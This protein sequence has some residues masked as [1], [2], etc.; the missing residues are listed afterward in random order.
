MVQGAASSPASADEYTGQDCPQTYQV[1]SNVVAVNITAIGAAG[2]AGSSDA[3]SG[4]GG[5]GAVV[6]AQVPVTPGEYLDAQPAQSV[7]NGGPSGSGGADNLGGVGGSSSY[8]STEDADCGGPIPASQ[9]LVEA[10]G[11][12]GGGAGEHG[13]L[14]GEYDGGNGGNAGSVG[15][16]GGAASGGGNSGQGGGGATQSGGGAGGAAGS[17][18][19][20]EDSDGPG[21]SGSLGLG[22][23][24]GE[25]DFDCITNPITG[26]I[27]CN[28]LGGSAGGGGGGGYSG[29]GGGGGGSNHGS[30]GG[31]GGSNYVTPSATNITE[32]LSTQQPSVTITPA[33]YATS[34]TVTSSINP[35]QTGQSVQYTATVTG[36]PDGQPV[37]FSATQGSTQLSLGTANLSHGVAA[38]S[39]ALGQGTWT[40]T[41]N[42]QGNATLAPS[43]G[44]VTQVAVTHV[45]SPPTGLTA[46]AVPNNQVSLSWTAPAQNGGG[47]ITGYDVYQGTTTGGES[48]TPVNA[49][50]LTGTSDSLSGL[51]DGTTYFFTV[52][53]INSAGLSPASAEASV[54]VGAATGTTVTVVPPAPAN[55]YVADEYDRQVTELPLSGGA[56]TT[57]GSSL[58]G[59]TAVAADGAGDV[60]IG[61]GPTGRVVEVP[62]GGGAQVAVGTFTDVEGLALDGA[63]DLYV[64]DGAGNDVLEVP[65]GG[66]PTRTIVSGLHDPTAVAVDAA[67]DLFIADSQAN[68]VLEVPT[69]GRPQTTV[70]TGLNGPDG[71]AVDAAGDVFIADSTNN[72]VVKVPA[73]GGSQGTVGSGLHYPARLAVDAAGDL[74]VADSGND[75]VVE[76]TPG[77][78]QSTLAFPA[79][80]DPVAV[81]AGPTPSAVSPGSSVTLRATVMGSP[82]GTA[83]TGTVTFVAGSTT[84]GH[85]DL[86]G[87]PATASLTTSALPTGFDQVTASYA[88]D[89]DS[90]PST[91]AS[92]A[93]TVANVPSAP[94]ALTATAGSGQATLQ[95]TAPSSNGGVPVTGY[96]VYQGTSAGHESV[97]PVNAAPVTGTSYTATGL[98]NGTTYFFTVRAVNAVGLSPASN[99]A[100]E[101]GARPTGTTVSAEPAPAP[102]LFIADADNNRIAEVAAGGGTPTTFAGGQNFPSTVATDSS[103]DVFTVNGGA[104]DVLEIPAGGGSSHVVLSGLSN[105]GGVAVDGAGDVFVADNGNNRVLEVPAGGGGTRTVG[106]GLVDPD[107]VAVDTVGDVFVTEPSAGEVVEIPA[108]GGPQ[109]VINRGIYDPVGVAVDAAGNLYV[110]DFDLGEVLEYGAIGGAPRVIAS[111]L[112][113]PYG[114]AVDGSDDVYVA[115][116]D[117]V[118]EIAPDGT[119]TV[120]TDYSHGVTDARGVAVDVPTAHAIP[121][122]PVTLQATVTSSPY[123]SAPTGTVT[124]KNGGTT[125]GTATLSGTSPTTASIT[126]SSLPTGTASIT[127]TYGGDAADLASA[128]SAPIAVSIQPTAP[129]APTGLALTNGSGQVSLTWTAPA[130]NGGSTLLGYNVYQGTSSGGESA[131]PVNA[132][133]ITGT[134]D[135]VTGLS[136]TG[137]YYFVVKAVNGVGSSGPSNEV[138][139]SRSPTG[140]SVALSPAPTPK[141]VVADAA[142]GVDQYSAAGGPAQPLGSGLNQPQG[143][144]ADAAGDVFIGDTSNNRVVEEP[145]GGG[146][147]ITVATGVN[148]IA[149]AVD[150]SGDLYVSDFSGNRVV[151]YPV[152]GGGPVTVMSGVDHPEGVAVDAAGDVYVS[153]PQE[154]NV[155]ELPVGQI[156]P[157]VAYHEV[158]CGMDGLAVD[159]TGTLYVAC[160]G[161]TSL[162]EVR[163]GGIVAAAGYGVGF[164]D[165]VG[166][167]VDPAG[168]VFVTNHDTGQLQEYPG[169]NLLNFNYVV[170]ASGY[171]NLQGVAVVPTRS[172]AV[173]GSPASVTATVQTSPAGGQPTGPVTFSDGAT[174]LG[175]AQL[176]GTFPD[177]ATFTTSSL[178]QGVHSLTASYGG[179]PDDTPSGPSAPASVDVEPTVPSAPVGVTATAGQAQVNL[180]WFAPQSNG[181]TPVTGYD[182][183]QGTSPGGESATPVNAAPITGTND[184]VT[185]LTPG[186]TY[187]FTVRAA[188]SQ[189]L[190]AAS[191][192][193]NAQPYA[194][195]STSLGADPTSAQPGQAVTLTAT[196]QTSP[197]G[198]SPTGTVT[199][200]LGSTTLGTAWLNGGS[201][202]TA[203]LVTSSLP[204]GADA[205]TASF[206]GQG[207]DRASGPSSPVTVTVEPV[208]PSAPSGLTARSAGHGQI[209]LSWNAPSANG[210][211]PVTGYDVYQGTSP[212]QE[213]ATPINASPLSTTSDTVSGLNDGTPYYFTVTASNVAGASPGSNEASATPAAASGTTLSASPPATP[214]LFVADSGLGQVVEVPA[215]G[216][217]QTPVGTG[218]SDPSDTAV[219]AAGDVFIADTG[220]NRVVEVPAGGGSQTRVGTGLSGPAGVAVDAAGDVFIAD[221]RHNRVVE[222]PA[223][224]GSQTTVGSGLSDPSGVAVDAAGDVFIADT[225][226]NRV[227]EVPAGGGSQTTVGT[228]LSDPSGVAVDAAGDVFIADTGNARVVEVPAG[229]SSQTAV[230]T[231][232]SAPAGVAVDPA[233]DVFIADTGNARVVEVPAG[234]GS[235]TTVGS[236]FSFPTGLAADVPVDHAIPGATV[237]VQAQVET[238][239]SG[240]APS[241]SVT[242][243][244]GATVL[245]TRPLSGSA[246]DT[247][248]FSTASLSTGTHELTATYSGNGAADPSPASAPLTVS[249]EPAVPGSPTG[250]TA[251]GQN[252]QVS[253]SWTAPTYTGGAPVTGYDVYMGTTP[254]GESVTP[255]NATPI[256]GTTD[257]VNGLIDGTPYYFTVRALNVAGASPASN[258][259]AATPD[260]RT[261]TAVTV[262]PPPAAGLVVAEDSNSSVIELPPGGGSAHYVGASFSGPTGLATDTLGDVFVADNGNNR[263]IEDPAAGGQTTVGTGLTHPN[264]VAVDQS[265]DVFIADS[266]NNRVVE[267]PAGGGPQ[268][269]LLSGLSTPWGVATDAAGDVFV[270]DT[271]NNRVLEL[272]AVGGNPI[273]LASGLLHPQAIAADVQGDVF[274][275]DTGNNQVDEI[276]AGGGALTTLLGP[277]SVTAPTGVAV[278]AAGNLYVSSQVTAHIVELPAGG[279]STLSLGGSVLTEPGGVAAVPGTTTGLPG[280]A[281]TL[282]ATVITSPAGAPLSGNVAF[283]QGGTEL[284]TATV[285]GNSPQTAS[286]TTTALPLGSDQVTAIYNGDGQDLASTSGPTTVDVATAPG[287]PTNLTGLAADT[288]ANL[289]WTPPVQ[290]NAGPVTGYDVYQGTASGGEGATPINPSP[291]TGTTDQVTGLTDGHA[292]YFTVKAINAEGISVASNEVSVTPGAGSGIVVTAVPAPTPDIYVANAGN[293]VVDKITGTTGS[294]TGVASSG[295]QEVSTDAIGDF[296]TINPSTSRVTEYP[297]SGGPTISIGSGLNY[298]TQLAVDPK[299]DIFIADTDNQRVVEEPAG[300]G[301]QIV[302]ASVPYPSGI[303]TDSAGDVYVAAQGSAQAVYK[304]SPGGVRSTFCS[305]LNFPQNITTNAAGDV[306]V[307]ENSIIAECF[308][309]GGEGGI[310]SGWQDVTGVAVDAAGNVYGTDA[311]ANQVVKVTPGGQ[312]STVGG[313]WSTPTAVAVDV[314]TAYRATGTPVT[315]SATLLSSSGLL[316]AGGVNFNSGSTLLGTATALGAAPGSADTASITTSALPAGTDQVT[317]TFVGSSTLDGATSPPI[318]VKV[319]PAPTAPTGLTATAGYQSASLSWTAA[320]ANGGDPVTGY[321]IYQGTS[322][323][324]E[325]ATPINA[326]PVTGTSY[327]ATGLSNG[328]SYYFRVKAVNL[329]GLSPASN[330][331]TATPSVPTGISVTTSPAATPDVFINDRA[332]N[333]VVE[334]PAGGGAQRVLVTGLNNP[335]GL[336]VDPAGDV[337]VPDASNNRVLEIFPNGTTTTVGTGLKNPVGVALDSSG[338]VFIADNGN[339]RIVEV[340]AQGVQ[341]VVP[342]SGLSGPSD[343]AVDSANDL[344]IVDRSNDRVLEIPAG[345]GPQTTVVTGL[346]TTQGMGVDAAGDLYIANTGANAVDEV[347]AG[348]STLVPILTGPAV[349]GPNDV[350]VDAGGDVFV[351]DGN[352]NRILEL[353]AGG[354]P[355]TTV[356]TGLL[357]PFSVSVDEPPTSLASTTTT[358]SATVLAP[359][360]AGSPAGTVTF[361]TGST[362]LGTAP[363]SGSVPDRATLTTSALAVGTNSITATYNAQGVYGSSTSA[364]ETVQ[365]TASAPGAPTALT[366][367]AAAGSVSLSWTAPASNG[368]APLTGYNVY[369]G[370]SPGGEAATPVNPSPLSGTSDTISGLTN[371]QTYYFTVKAVNA[372]GSSAPSNEFTASP[373]VSSSL[374][375]TDT[376]AGVETGGSFAFTATVSSSGTTPTGTV[377]WALTGPGSPTCAPSTL[378]NGVGSCTVSPASAGT[379]TAAATYA[380]DASHRGS[381]GSDTEATVAPAPI[382]ATVSGQQTYASSPA[383]SETDDAPGGVSLVGTLTCTGLAGPT[384]VG[385]GLGVGTYTVDPNTC[386]GLSPSDASD[387]TVVYQG[388]PGGFAVTP[389]ATTVQLARTTSGTRALFD[390]TV[391]GPGATPTGTVSWTITGH[392]PGRC[393]S[394]TLAGGQATCLL[395]QGAASNDVVTATYSGDADHQG[396][397]FTT[398]PF[399]AAVNGGSTASVPY[400]TPATF[401]EAGLPAGASG[402]VAFRTSGGTLLCTVTLPATSCTTAPTLGGGSYPGVTA[403]YS[404]DPSHAANTATSTLSLTVRALAQRVAFTTPAPTGAVVGGTAPVAATGGASGNPVVLTVSGV[405]VPPP[406]SVS[407]GTL[408]FTHAGTC[409]VTATQAAS[410]DYDA[411]K[412]TLQFHIAGLATATSLTAP[413]SLT[414]GAEGAGR[415]SVVVTAAQGTPTGS[416]NVMAGSTVLC[417]VRLTSSDNG[418]CSPGRSRLASGTYQVS[419]RFQ[420]NMADYLTSQSAPASLLVQ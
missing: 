57:V 414:A 288:G 139:T 349:S 167:A 184:T 379:Y 144:A 359:A 49:S 317:A 207:A 286:L 98:V 47:A 187:Y 31:G 357:G 331:A 413:S 296:F 329:E 170:L 71:L 229:G 182:V 310:G 300:G 135:T 177:T 301:A 409:I 225:G 156:S 302:F 378:V 117:Q 316:P 28:Q 12:G 361:R 141:V 99:E 153:E 67:G 251:T 402:T 385:P 403:A 143:V 419:A 32:G 97:T 24:G 76:I 163:N 224:G 404:G 395:T 283:W 35:S 205:I 110:S 309:G 377:T 185:G 146:G 18:D 370:T 194:L 188:N 92:T 397:S 222:V 215:G 262:S 322:P 212:G 120:A 330:E 332:N 118:I 352:N 294:S 386:S 339:N 416:V 299:G 268:Q 327:S 198:G 291:I 175:T 196:V 172:S 295:S 90:G 96:D 237:T 86:S 346:G 89:S 94:R 281:V 37:T 363:L 417:T 236:G 261:G 356:G 250:L 382:T 313:G 159:G 267:V 169:G 199:F 155:L 206:G 119:Q 328:T 124:F 393:Q 107:Q 326:S 83:A 61:E 243:A 230:G 149:L 202:D 265:G 140:I 81:A 228:G 369:Q 77:G 33:V 93:V 190:G 213:G 272:P 105:P 223:G 27:S 256:T 50:P 334:V 127:A 373:L 399:T 64:A 279:G 45:P 30:G 254:G 289:S 342:T 43:S 308:P 122:A 29:G 183:Y 147:Q 173:L 360:L 195:T 383:F 36:V 266:G 9:L 244:D 353:P 179:D 131:T 26:I 371:G 400:G 78:S 208:A 157:V 44:S 388:A 239:P 162:L 335:R 253:L 311:E 368:G 319:A 258:E 240:G 376:A 108:G 62:A 7:Q 112:Y 364:P 203:T 171:P 318:T 375:V 280:A 276:P 73:G 366:G 103:G 351:A 150:A 95:W 56:A 398:T 58:Q 365:T 325:S 121:G 21:T 165:P 69:N 246:P 204:T 201:P 411:G 389:A 80:D 84:L 54:T 158:N 384:A 282:T 164:T 25:A 91:S 348:T 293:G 234:G 106:S 13:T 14:Y 343:L 320:G 133:L 418:S 20:S 390:A 151:E 211:A 274:V 65:A 275:A 241:G 347:P 216:G 333:R 247:A 114:L 55:V 101:A 374:G 168:D 298:P 181:G 186:T 259:A 306:Y 210:G 412:A 136:P 401:S 16:A 63:G 271:G 8:V 273:T 270:A 314:P 263:V 129:G 160:S 66:G 219:D 394:Q 19:S 85:A 341:S 304:Y 200:T 290:G 381:S 315:L 189:G 39:Y 209:T 166:V 4:S 257:T 392:F 22:G 242:F 396:S 174:T 126:T 260:H 145:A 410:A 125:L 3:N 46:G 130:S 128:T 193:V 88:G 297:A 406:C 220:D 38:V 231:G 287:P 354:G 17:P 109:V 34:T 74:F 42:Y 102:D 233:G 161:E 227:V 1:P 407:G 362:V 116:S 226:D 420:P 245:A 269:T 284:G 123:T 60:Y 248:T 249:V 52:R 340:S 312:Q 307:A 72:R 87:S 214:D 321:D 408:T 113:S 115:N 180:S 82:S 51:T 79:L 338:D 232:L 217:S 41:A 10:G 252:T 176:S 104:G 53:A 68:R 337:Y 40:V 15:Q 197:T 75:R 264:G 235:Q 372:V 358:L 415:F 221:T 192:E 2:Q 178:T 305:N 142:R 132:T 218:L 344:F 324:A 11:G 5:E 137:N 134:S 380:G 100:Q 148:A 387:Y 48:T 323:G 355:S 138:S 336:A 70:G 278:D 111:D 350:A 303:A 292:Y 345:G 405:G 277:S 152:G 238:S 391:S 285:S 59:A 23:D 191:S 255:V 367:Q 6:T 154:G